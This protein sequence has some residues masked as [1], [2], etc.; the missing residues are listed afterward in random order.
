MTVNQIATSAI[1]GY[2]TDWCR[3]NAR[4]LSMGQRL[5]LAFQIALAK[6]STYVEGIYMP[7]E[8]AL[9]ETKPFDPYGSAAKYDLVRMI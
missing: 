5:L 8:I 3:E 4:N 7:H 6:K 1:T 9:K 2:S